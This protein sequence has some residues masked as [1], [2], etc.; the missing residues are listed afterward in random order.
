VQLVLSY[1]QIPHKLEYF[2][3]TNALAPPAD[4]AKGSLPV[5][6]A[7]TPS[8]GEET[9]RVADSLSICEFLA[10]EY[11]DKSL[12]PRDPQLRA[13]ARTAAAQMHSGFAA[14]RD[15]YPSNF[16]AR[17]TGP[18]IPF[19]KA[20]AKDTRKLVELWSDLRAAAKRRLKLLK[21]ADEGFLC[22]GFSIADAFF[23]PVLWVSNVFFFLMLRRGLDDVV[24][25]DIHLY[26]PHLYADIDFQAAL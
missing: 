17:F 14:L 21:E 13:L 3:F 5:L 18:G 4:L 8:T 24:A 12:W 9:L 11:P 1:F 2:N 26:I 22:G 20:T 10:E 15:A 7:V 23:W 25:I 16:V 6:D 19:D